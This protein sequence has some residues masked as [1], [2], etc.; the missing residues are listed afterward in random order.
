MARKKV[1][2]RSTA[3]TRRNLRAY[4]DS[5]GISTYEGRATS[6]ISNI[7]LANLYNSV[8]GRSIPYNRRTFANDFRIELVESAKPPK[9]VKGVTRYQ[10]YK[11]YLLSPEWEEI[12]QTLFASRG[13]VC[14]MC[15]SNKF[16]QVH[17]ITY[18][19]L[20]NEDPADLLVVCNSCHEKIH[21]KDKPK[22]QRLTKEG[23]VKVSLTFIANSKKLKMS[24]TTK[25]MSVMLPG[26]KIV[27]I[28]ADG[29][30]KLID[31]L[32]SFPPKP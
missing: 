9:S 31:F 27:E 32:N 20:F 4:L 18:D 12:R 1:D 19:R 21:G 17:H 23:K 14:E 6:C 25:R 3:V 5:M 16:I 24:S 7:D 22:P 13:R 30:Q 10:K 29:L 11:N 15:G 2:L 26:R 28:D 8:S